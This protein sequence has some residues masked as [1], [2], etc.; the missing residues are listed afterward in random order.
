MTWYGAR[1]YCTALGKRLPTE[2]EREFAARGPQGRTYPWG[3]APPAPTRARYG[4]GWIKTVPA[5]SLPQ[6]ATPKVSSTLPAMFTNGRRAS[7]SLIPIMRT[8]VARIPI[9]WRIG[10]CAAALQ[11][12]GRRRCAA[13]GAEPAFRAAR[14]PAITLSG[15]AAPRTRNDYNRGG[16]C[17]MPAVSRRASASRTRM[18]PIVRS[19]AI[20]A[21]GTST[22][23]RSSRRG[24]G[25]VSSGSFKARSS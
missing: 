20:S 9:A 24:C 7:R 13:L 21:S 17:S 6:G 4:V 22:N 3:E 2:A 25:R 11:I 19:G 8:T 18:P 14:L 16:S 15:S 5:G 12:P 10:W 1:D 23:A